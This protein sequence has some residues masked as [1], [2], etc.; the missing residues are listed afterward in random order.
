MTTNYGKSI[1]SR[2]LNL[3]HEENMEYMKILVRYLHERLLYRI[4]V[5]RYNMNFFLKGGSLLFAYNRFKA[6][7]TIDIDLLGDRIS[8]N[9][10]YLKSV[11]TEICSID[12]EN[13]GVIFDVQT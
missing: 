13:D 2:L 4:S 10:I 8:N 6:R 9:A 11:F 12:C 1:K 3:A 5:S 7:P